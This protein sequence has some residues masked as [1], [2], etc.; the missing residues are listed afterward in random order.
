MK[1]FLGMVLC[2]GMISRQLQAQQPSNKH[3]WYQVKTSASPQNVWRVWTHVEQWK[4]WDSGLKDA[5]MSE[6]FGLHARGTL[7]SLEGRK[8]KFKVVQYVEGESYTFKTSLPLGGLYV[9][10]FWTEEEGQLVFT[11]EV[12]FRGLTGGLFAKAF[13]PKFRDM[14]PEVMEEVKRLA[15]ARP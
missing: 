3:F 10:R 8:S 6:P 9:K 15:E 12:W 7:I 1:L 2:L 4:D 14:L 5:F 13:G 11:H